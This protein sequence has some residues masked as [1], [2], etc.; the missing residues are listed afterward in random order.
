MKKQ[1][2]RLRIEFFNFFSVVLKKGEQWFCNVS[3]IDIFVTLLFIFK[4]SLKFIVNILVDIFVSDYLYFIKRFR[5]TYNVSSSIYKHSF[6][7]N[8]SL[9]LLK[10][11]VSIYIIFKS[12][13]WLEREVYDM[14]GIKFVNNW[15]LRRILT[16]Y[17]FFGFPLRKDF[18]LSGYVELLYDEKKRVTFETLVEFMQEMRFFYTSSNIECWDFSGPLN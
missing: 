12:S 7:F 18:P 1:F 9:K 2:F 4:C 16:D 5:V 8:Q 13:I 3:K 17:T 11:F 15:D 14:F 10:S 6:F